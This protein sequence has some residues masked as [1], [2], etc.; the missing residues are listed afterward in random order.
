MERDSYIEG[1]RS[2]WLGERLGEVFFRAMA[3][4][5]DDQSMQTAW[6][7]LAQLENVTG[8]R[9]AAVLETY[10]ETVTADGTIEVGDDIIQQYT[11]V[12]H[13]DAMKHMKDVVEQALVRFD[14]LLAVAPESDVPQVRFL[15]QHEQALLTFV[16]REIA[17]DRANALADVEQLLEQAG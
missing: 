14:Q 6:R 2:A 17:G 15:V 12:P 16:E 1:I 5:T 9:M 4:R 10:G 11:G 13:L 3:N 7:T 8:K